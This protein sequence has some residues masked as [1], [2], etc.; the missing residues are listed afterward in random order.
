MVDAV[1]TLEGICHITI[2]KDNL[3]PWHDSRITNHICQELHHVS[4]NR[5]V[6]DFIKNSIKVYENKPI[7]APNSLPGQL[8][9]K[10]LITPDGGCYHEMEEKNLDNWHYSK[11]AHFLC[12]KLNEQAFESMTYQ[13]QGIKN[14]QP[15]A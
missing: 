11:L 2:N 9:C 10:A 5:N 14:A 12:Q 6:P 7:D 1:I 8:I 4:L 13:Y 3:N 15:G